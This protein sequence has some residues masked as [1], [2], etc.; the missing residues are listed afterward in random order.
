[1]KSR[2]SFGSTGLAI[3]IGRAPSVGDPDQLFALL[4]R[5]QT[6]AQ[7]DKAEE[8]LPDVNR[9]IALQPDSDDVVRVWAMV[10]EK[11]GKAKS[12][13]KELRQQVEANPDDGVAWLQLGLLYGAQH[14]T[15]KAIDAFS[16]VIKLGEHR[17]FAYQVRADTYLN[18]GMQ[19]E[20]ISDY[21][22]ALK[23]DQN[24]SGVLNNLAWVLATSPE[25]ELRRG[26]KALELALKACE[27][28]NYQQA[29]ILSTLAAAYAENGDFKTARKW[30]QKSVEIGDDSLKDQLRKELAS[31]EQEQPWREKQTPQ[32]EERG[33]EDEK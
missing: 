1:M 16:A 22:E 9:A 13:V 28:T 4:I 7:L 20:A 24:N 27:V 11:A 2:W 19:K 31:Y 26:E 25:Q 12:A 30:S 32:V 21:H 8:A 17:S 14:Q 6:L 5:A 29:H 10:T 33:Q 23:L 3:T 18:V 15:G